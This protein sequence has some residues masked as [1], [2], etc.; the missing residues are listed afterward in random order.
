MLETRHSQIE[1]LG[2]DGFQWFIAQVAPDKYWRDKHNQNFENGFRAKIRI[3]GY[4]PDDDTIPDNDLPWAHF[5]CAAQF[6]SGNM[7][8]GTSFQV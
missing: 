5:L 8:S 1:F 3:I 7:D 4:H 6:G 2:K